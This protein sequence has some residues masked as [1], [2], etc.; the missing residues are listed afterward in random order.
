M[1]TP[2]INKAM[3]FTKKLFEFIFIQNI[4]WQ[5]IPDFLRDALILVF[6]MDVNFLILASDRALRIGPFC[7]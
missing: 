7:D 4:N 1:Q 5:S 2:L 6:P 3:F